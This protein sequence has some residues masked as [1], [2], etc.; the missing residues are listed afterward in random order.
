VSKGTNKGFTLIELMI[1]VAIIGI[2][3]SILIPELTKNELCEKLETESQFTAF[4]G[5][6]S[7]GSLV[8]ASVAQDSIVLIITETGLF[9]GS[10]GAISPTIILSAGT[11]AAAYL[12]LKGAC[13]SVGRSL[14]FRESLIEKTSK[15]MEIVNTAYSRGCCRFT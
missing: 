15:S 5:G 3:W 9:Y 1:V 2:L 4:I 11:A 6:L 12:S 14:S 13:T 8:T 7:V 10:V